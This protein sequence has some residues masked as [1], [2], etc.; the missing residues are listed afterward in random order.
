[1]TGT[2]IIG[3]EFEMMFF[4]NDPLG[5][6]DLTEMIADTSAGSQLCLL[7]GVR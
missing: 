4:I 1:M 5:P 3:N 7:G 6:L 2:I